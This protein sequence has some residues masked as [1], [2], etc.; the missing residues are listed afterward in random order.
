MSAP[1]VLLKVSSCYRA[2]F[3][4]TAACSGIR[5]KEIN[6]V[7]TVG[8]EWLLSVKYCSI[9][10]KQNKKNPVVLFVCKFTILIC[11]MAWAAIKQVQRMITRSAF[12][13]LYFTLSWWINTNA[14]CLPQRGR[15]GCSTG[16][17]TALLK[18]IETFCFIVIALI[19]SWTYRHQL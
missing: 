14:P 5:V 9:Y 3:S 8:Y 11:E 18:T 12:E 6:T 13:N 7:E 19:L 2:V 10:L 4:A 1:L 15:Q 16:C 17:S